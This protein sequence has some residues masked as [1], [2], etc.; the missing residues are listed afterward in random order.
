MLIHLVVKIRTDLRLLL[1]F[2][3]I[4]VGDEHTVVGYHP[5]VAVNSTCISEIRHVLGLAWRIRR[6]VA[7]VCHHGDDIVLS[8]FQT[9]RYIH[10][11][12]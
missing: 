4:W 2:S 3:R 9:L 7:V 10:N 12:R 8:V 6:V 11:H 5:A 1:Y